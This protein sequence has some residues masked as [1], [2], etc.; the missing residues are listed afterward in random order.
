MLLAASDEACE[1]ALS[2]AASAKL[3]DPTIVG[4]GG[5]AGGLGA[6]RGARLGW[7]LVIPPTPR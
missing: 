7:P 1:L 5:G 3:D 4:V 6:I 2:V